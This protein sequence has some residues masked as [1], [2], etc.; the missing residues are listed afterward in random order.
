MIYKRE[1][2]DGNVMNIFAT[3]NKANENIMEYFAPPQYSMPQP[4]M[5]FPSMQ[6]V[7]HKT[8]ITTQKTSE[9]KKD[10]DDKHDG[11]GDFLKVLLAAGMIGAGGYATW[12]YTRPSTTEKFMKTVG[13]AALKKAEEYHSKLNAIDN[14][15]ASNPEE[16]ARFRQ[17]FSRMAHTIGDHIHPKL[18]HTMRDMSQYAFGD[19]IATMAKNLQNGHN[20]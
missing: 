1:L 15:L 12:K 18:G 7:Q 5:A 17:N 8:V 20:Q 14:R 13:K 2:Q 4:Q 11:I 6:P 9:K 16:Q 10:D 3:L 19:P